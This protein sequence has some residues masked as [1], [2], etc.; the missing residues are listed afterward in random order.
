MINE[1]RLSLVCNK[2]HTVTQMPMAWS[3]VCIVD[4]TR[5]ATY[6]TYQKHAKKPLLPVSKKN[7]S[8]ITNMYPK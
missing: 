8:A 2:W 6:C 7:V 5:Y 3:Y 4:C 1:A